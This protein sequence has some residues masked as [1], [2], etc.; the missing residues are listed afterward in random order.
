LTSEVKRLTDLVGEKVVDQQVLDETR[1][2]LESSE[3][4][5]EAAQAA[6][7]TRDAERLAAEVKGR[8]DLDWTFLAG[9]LSE[10]AGL[11]PPPAQ[12]SP[13]PDGAA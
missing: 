7:R 13:R 12:S 11:A 9:E 1:R 3:A 6:V 8:G 10:A 4:A 2:Q 5:L